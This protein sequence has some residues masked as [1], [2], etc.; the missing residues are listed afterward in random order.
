MRGASVLFIALGSL[1]LAFSLSVPQSAAYVARG[2]PE[3][4]PSV[5]VKPR[6]LNTYHGS[7]VVGELLIITDEPSTYSISITGVPADWLG[8]SSSV[9]VDSQESVLYMINPRDSGDYWL[10]IEVSGSGRVIELEQRLWVGRSQAKPMSDGGAAAGDGNGGGL[11]G[12][13]AYSGQDVA[14][15]ISAGVFIAAIITVFL[16]FRFFKENLY[17][18]TLAA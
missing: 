6:F 15:L 11:T 8:Y 3:A 16:G 5:I 10:S 7:P 18:G 14:L 1:L 12:M 4:L 17:P 9:H 13:F 2:E